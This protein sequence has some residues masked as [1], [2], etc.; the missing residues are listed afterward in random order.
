MGGSMSAIADSDLL[1]QRFYRHVESRPEAV[2]L[3]QPHD[4]GQV[5]DY[6][7]AQA[8]DQAARMAAHLRS[9][10]LPR[11]SQIAIVSKNCAHFFIAELAIWM[12]GHVTVALYPTLAANTVRY[13]L[14]HSESRLLFVGKLDTWE[15]MRAG[16]PEDLPRITLPLG[17]ETDDPRWDDIVARTPPL[18][19][20]PTRAAD[21]R[22][23]IIYTS[24]STGT[25]KGVLHTF[26]TLSV[27]T[28]VLAGTL[29]VVPEDRMLSYLPLAHAMDRWLSFCISLYSGCH[30]YFAESLDTFVQDLQRARP[31][32]FVS[33]PR[34]WLKFQHGVFEKL[35][36][37]K[38]ARLQKIPIVRGI[39]NRK[40]LKGLGLDQVRFAGSGSAPISAEL[41]AWYRN[42]GLELLEGYGMSENFNF[43]HL[44]RP[45]HGRAGY[46]GHPHPGVECKLSQDGEILVRSPGTMVGYF[47][48]PEL[49]R[50]VLSDDGW[51]RTGDRGEIDEDGR[52]KITGRV[53][54]LFKTSKGKYVSPAPIEN[55]INTDPHVELSVV[56]GAGHPVTHAV[57]Q[58]SEE[59]LPRLG[60]P[61]MK[62]RLTADLETML[63]RVNAEIEEFERL[64]FVVV[65]KDRW[66]IEE[67]QLTPTMKIKRG[68]IEEMYATQLEG[69]YGAGAKVIWET[70]APGAP[71]E[72]PRPSPAAAAPRMG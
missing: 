29:S 3:T 27:P 50:E 21:D 42:L 40:I 9:L 66:T 43:S 64:G 2:Y 10:D 54:E 6:T 56:A 16:V 62:D 72:A 4:G 30:I 19:G 22:S 60:D 1:L 18:E 59:V 33:V 20:K 38:L 11:E 68:A 28:K 24:G 45:G 63:K 31:T 36:P 47:K 25:P 37:E 57:I 15:E 39:V 69:W 32:L 5:T 48:Q 55:L 41:L 44:T 35:P 8:F 67:G 58:L 70:T 17:P 34:L 61:G 53:K 52:L 13:I 26:R 65:A 51:L 7:F 14:E 12:S 49:T 23:I 71:V 46:I